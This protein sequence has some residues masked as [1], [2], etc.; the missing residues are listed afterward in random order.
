[1]NTFILSILNLFPVQFLYSGESRVHYSEGG[2]PLTA[3]VNLDTLLSEVS[4]GESVMSVNF[5]MYILFMMM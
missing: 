3:E 2:L 5:D 1:V 4:I